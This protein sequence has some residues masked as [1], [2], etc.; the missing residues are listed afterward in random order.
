MEQGSTTWGSDFSRFQKALLFHSQELAA[1]AQPPRLA[2]GRKKI[3]KNQFAKTEFF[4]MP[5]PLP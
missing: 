5:H 2:I 3:E 4:F 1:M